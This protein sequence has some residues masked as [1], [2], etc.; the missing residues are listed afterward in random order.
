M[1]KD[2]GVEWGGRVL[3]L[4]LVLAYVTVVLPLFKVRV[5]HLL[6]LL[7]LTHMAGGLWVYPVIFLLLS[8]FVLLFAFFA[9]I[10]DVLAITGILAVFMLMSFLLQLGLPRATVTLIVLATVI[11]LAAAVLFRAFWEGARERKKLREADA[12]VR[13]QPQVGF[14]KKQ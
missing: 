12:S 6:L 9:P 13:H 7:A 4:L 2:K 3:F 14:T 10:S 1:N 8:L 11:T 5:I